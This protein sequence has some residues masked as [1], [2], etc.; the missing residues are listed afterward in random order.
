MK[1]ATESTPLAQKLK[2]QPPPAK[3]ASARAPLWEFLDAIDLPQAQIVALTGVSRGMISLWHGGK[4]KLPYYMRFVLSWIGA[5]WLAAQERY[6]SQPEAEIS[7]DLA[8]RGERLVEGWR[9]RV[10]EHL[11]EAHR[12]QALQWLELDRIP[13]EEEM[14]AITY[15]VNK[16][17]WFTD[18]AQLAAFRA[19]IQSEIEKQRA[20]K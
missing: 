13:A 20:G 10:A 3:G 9:E 7:R 6:W 15:A 5:Q 19:E 8:R 16:L 11:A 1:P 14:K 18:E 4:R 12:L 17:N 2:F